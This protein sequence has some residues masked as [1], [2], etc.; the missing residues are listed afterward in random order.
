MKAMKKEIKNI[1]EDIDVAEK[2]LLET[3]NVLDA[4]LKRLKEDEEML[5]EYYMKLQESS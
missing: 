2:E 3:R 1:I 5:K 4:K